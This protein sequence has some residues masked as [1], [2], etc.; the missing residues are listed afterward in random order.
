MRSG[1]RAQLVG[2]T[3]VEITLVADGDSQAL[4]R[5][6]IV[7]STGDLDS[8]HGNVVWAEVASCDD[9]E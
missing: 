7:A 9:D 2:S 5:V 8:R 1:I 6:T 3:V 4:A